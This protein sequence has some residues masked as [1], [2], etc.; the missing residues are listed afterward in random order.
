MIGLKWNSMWP[1]TVDPDTASAPISYVCVPCEVGWRTDGSVTECWLCGEP[2][3]L[4]IA[5]TRIHLKSN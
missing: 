5:A 3:Q 1:V 2:G 4:G